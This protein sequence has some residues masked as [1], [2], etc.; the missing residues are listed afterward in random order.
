MAFYYF[1]T[2]QDLVEI[3]AD[4]E[5]QAPV[6]IVHEHNK[7]GTQKACFQSAREIPGLTDDDPSA[8]FRSS[9]LMYPFQCEPVMTEVEAPT[10]TLMCVYRTDNP[11]AVDVSQPSM[12]YVESFPRPELTAGEI[13]FFAM[14]D[15]PGE[16]NPS[17][18][19]RALANRIRKAIRKRS[20]LLYS[21]GTKRIYIARRALEKARNKEID[22][23]CCHLR[24]SAAESEADAIFLRDLELPKAALRPGSK[25]RSRFDNVTPIRNYRVRT[26]EFSEPADP[27]LLFVAAYDDLKSLFEAACDAGDKN[28][29]R[30]GPPRFRS[31]CQSP[32]DLPGL[33]ASSLKR[34][35]E[36]GVISWRGEPGDYR[37]VHEP[38]ELADY[39]I[40]LLPDGYIAPSMIV[41][42]GGAHLRGSK[43]Q[44]KRLFCGYARLVHGTGRAHFEA[45][46]EA[47]L[48]RH[49]D[50]VQLPDLPVDIPVLPDAKALLDADIELDAS[51]LSLHILHHRIAIKPDNVV[52][53]PDRPD[54]GSG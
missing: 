22:L 39:R 5:A 2:G 45:F 21:E 8:R 46:R 20:S 11:D 47:V 23:T 6:R 18:D 52:A 41:F 28:Y 31:I 15:Y 44:A 43:R 3:F 7:T 30:L 54:T 1:A 51:L 12:L 38:F 40:G 36:C 35:I 19:A 32:D 26:V 10:R 27:D 24:W 13:R 4:I 9:F 37:R 53:F 14:T 33:G 34:E 42:P 49:V 17:S 50:V 48:S 16:R 29:S 25:N